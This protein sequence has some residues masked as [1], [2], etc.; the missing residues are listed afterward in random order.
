MNSGL[1]IVHHGPGRE[2]RCQQRQPFQALEHKVKQNKIQLFFEGKD[3]LD[4][5]EAEAQTERANETI[6]ETGRPAKT[7]PVAAEATRRD[8]D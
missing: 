5:L 8:G 7:L 4:R 1:C 2:D 6:T 3:G